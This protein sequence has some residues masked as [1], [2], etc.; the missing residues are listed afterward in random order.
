M[1][2]I[3]IRQNTK[4]HISSNFKLLYTENESTHNFNSAISRNN[5]FVCFEAF[6][7]VSL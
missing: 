3:T 4:Y 2:L 7:S 1:Q 5:I 6:I